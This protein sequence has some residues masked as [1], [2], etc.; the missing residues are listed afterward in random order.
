MLMISLCSLYI[1]SVHVVPNAHDAGSPMCA[2]LW[3]GAGLGG[4]VGEALGEAFGEAL[5]ALNEAMRP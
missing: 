3:R 1:C 4:L 5:K 2:G